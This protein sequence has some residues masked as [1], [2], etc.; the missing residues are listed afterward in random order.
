M[1]EPRLVKTTVFNQLWER[2]RHAE[3][4]QARDPAF[5]QYNDYVFRRHDVIPRVNP[6]P[7]TLTKGRYS[8]SGGEHR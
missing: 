8:R 2:G 4:H 3:L 7:P 1:K 6:P 5:I